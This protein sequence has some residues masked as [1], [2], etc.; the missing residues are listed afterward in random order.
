MTPPPDVNS[1]VSPGTPGQPIQ[2]LPSTTAL[3]GVS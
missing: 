3:R 1:G 2:S